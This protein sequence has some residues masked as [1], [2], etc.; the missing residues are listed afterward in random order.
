MIPSI[1]SGL[2]IILATAGV[3]EAAEMCSGRLRVAQMLISEDGEIEFAG[4]LEAP[5]SDVLLVLARDDDEK[6]AVEMLFE[7]LERP[8]PPFAT[9]QSAADL[10]PAVANA[11]ATML[12]KS[13]AREASLREALLAMRMEAEETRSALARLRDDQTRA[14]APQGLTWAM[15][16]DPLGP[17]GAFVFAGPF[18]AEIHAPVETQGLAAIALHLAA[19]RLAPGDFLRIR[20]LG[21]EKG[22]VLGAWEI[23]AAEIPREPDWLVLD[24]PASLAIARQSVVVALDGRFSPESRIALSGSASPEFPNSPALRLYR[25]PHPRLTVSPHWLWDEVASPIGL[26]GSRP[27][28]PNTPAFCIPGASWLGSVLLGAAAK[29]DSARGVQRFRIAGGA[30]AMLVFPNISLAG[31]AAV[32][33]RLDRQ[34]E[35]GAEVEMALSLLPGDH[36]I[37]DDHAAADASSFCWSPLQTLNG[38][39]GAALLA[40]PNDAP[41]FAHV[42]ISMRHRGERGDDPIV[43]EIDGVWLLPRPCAA[44]LAPGDGFVTKVALGDLRNASFEDVTAD[45]IYADENYRHIDM[46]I[47]ALSESGRFWRAVKFK[48]FEDRGQCGMEFRHRPG[49]PDCFVLWPG[50]ETDRFG[51]IYKICGAAALAEAIADLP[52]AVDRRLLAALAYVLPDVVRALAARGDLPSEQAAEWTELARRL[53]ESEDEG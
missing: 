6:A 46:T 19:D 10:A 13:V 51:E 50:T 49:W 38:H 28:P 9:G 1:F 40:L 25:A 42:A 15:W 27:P 47:A 30:G 26:D 21:E 24:F 23:A 52:S 31:F 41:D 29:L 45:E 44:G 14:L 39:D 48:L 37:G 33:A 3:A 36:P 43:V 2:P 5:P 11:L 34:S 17:E 53:C 35:S 12:E 32:A 16:T 8:L 20:A 18:E 4:G 7:R 22:V